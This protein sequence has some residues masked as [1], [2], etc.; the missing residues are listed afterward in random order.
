M[1]RVHPHEPRARAGS[2]CRERLQVAEVADAPVAL[3]TQGVEL[4]RRAP[5][6]PAIGENWRLV[7]AT[8]ADDDLCRGGR[9]PL[10]EQRVAVIPEG[11]GESQPETRA[12]ERFAFDFRP[13]ENGQ[14]IRLQRAGS[15]FPAFELEDPAVFARRAGGGNDDLQI[16]RRTRPRNLDRRERLA[17]GSLLERGERR[18]GVFRGVDGN[19][20]RL[21]QAQLGRVARVAAIAPQVPILELDAVPGAEPVEF[22]AHRER[23]KRSSARERPSSGYAAPAAKDACAGIPSGAWVSTSAFQRRRARPAA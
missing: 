11:Q 23:S 8:R 17:P 5:H 18:A 20:H 22:G 9:L 21:Q 15:A 2:E 13:R 3:R 6:A 19:A 4:D 10:F 16:H 1:Q 14:R 7:A 12:D